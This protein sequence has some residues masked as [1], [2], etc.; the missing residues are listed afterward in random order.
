[1]GIFIEATSLPDDGYG[2]CQMI[3]LLVAY[4]YI[5][6]TG[7]KSVSDG[8]ELLLLV[9]K[10]AGI[11]GSIILPVL[12]AV[13]DG[14]IVIF[15]GLGANAQ[16]ELSVGVGALAGS[17]I[18]LLTIPWGLSIIAGRVNIGSDGKPIYRRPIGDSTP[19]PHRKLHPP[20]NRDMFKTGV[21]VDGSVGKNGKVMI[22]CA[23]SYVFIQGPAFYYLKHDK[24]VGDVSRDEQNW[25]IGAFCLCIVCF[26][27]YLAMEFLHNTHSEATERIVVEVAQKELQNHHLSLIAVMAGV[28]ETHE[29][30]TKSTSSPVT[31]FSRIDGGLTKRLRLVLKP[32]FAKYDEDRSGY[33]SLGEVEF[34]LK[35]LGEEVGT[36]QITNF[37]HQMDA[38][39]DGL[40]DYSEFIT[41]MA[42]YLID[43]M[44][45]VKAHGKKQ[46][47]QEPKNKPAKDVEL[48]PVVAAADT[49]TESVNRSSAE[50]GGGEDDDDE[51]GSIPEDIASMPLEKQQAAIKRRAFGLMLL[52]TVLVLAFADPMVNVFSSLGDRIHVPPF[53]ISFVLAPLASNA[54]EVLASYAFAL[55]KTEK[56]VS[57]SL[58]QLEGAAILNNTFC[59][60]LFLGLIAFRKLE[61]NFSAETVSILTIE[62]IMFLMSFKKVHRVIDAYIVLAMYPL[63]IA[64]VVG[65]NIAKIDRSP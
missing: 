27:G 38:N 22:A 37:F 31:E 20:T 3:F 29:S 63:S 19:G 42:S 24:A 26:V 35:D 46:K 51:D 10:Y 58:V 36:D 21:S 62:I 53:Y 17:T 8:A 64:L 45:R 49:N 32:F 18:M 41:A 30:E 55:K 13:P 54:S 47:E 50:P 25:A 48:M 16:E 4:G 44:K 33:L 6:Y 12:G 56:T 9:P 59:L 43:N 5:L 14:A 7:S 61:W 65:L 1:M 40:I 60:A 52:G 2:F 57:V 23:A 28:L 11:V 15:S 39:S 34:L